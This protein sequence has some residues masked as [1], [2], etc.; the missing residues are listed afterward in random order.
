MPKRRS[1]SVLPRN[2][3]LSGVDEYPIAAVANMVIHNDSTR[4]IPH[5]YAITPLIHSM[6]LAAS[7]AV[8]RNQCIDSTMDVNSELITGYHVVE[9]LRSQSR[10]RQSYAGIYWLVTVARAHYRE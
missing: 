7:D 3:F 1:S 6:P 4:S 8:T 5:V 2:S 9:N 10:F